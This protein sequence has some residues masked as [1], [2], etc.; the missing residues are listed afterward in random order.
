FDDTWEFPRN[1]LTLENILGEGEFGQVVRAQAKNLNGHGSTTVVAVKMLKP[2]ASGTEYQDLASEFQLM[3]E[4]DHPNVVKLLGVCS[5]KGPL[6]LIVEYCEFGS[7]RSFLRASQFRNKGS[8]DDKKRRLDNEEPEGDEV[9]EITIRDLFVFAWQI[10]KG[11][12]YLAGLKIV[13]RDLAA[14]NVLVTEGLK[15]KISDFGLSRD[16]YEMDTY[17]KMS[18]G[19]I[20]VKWMA[21]ESLY[22][23][24]YTTKSDIWSY[25]IVLWET[26]TLGASPY[27]G[28][29]AERLFPLL[30]TGYRMDRPE[31]CPDELYAIMQKC[32][33]SEPEQ[34]PTFAELVRFL[35]NILQQN[36]D[37]LDLSNENYIGQ[38]STFDIEGKDLLLSMD[39]EIKQQSTPSSTNTDNNNQQKI[40]ST[41]NKLNMYRNLKPLNSDPTD[42]DLDLPVTSTI[43][44]IAK[45]DQEPDSCFQEKNEDDCV[46]ESEPETESSRLLSQDLNTEIKDKDP[47]LILPPGGLGSAFKLPVSKQEQNQSRYRADPTRE[48]RPRIHENLTYV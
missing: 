46:N 36:T 14:R 26:V 48:S 12:D 33:K 38:S 2:E 23:Q 11:M 24:V 13:H 28:I 4:V 27:P 44:E 9:R 16:V 6:Y 7:L 32:W 10:A 43:E 31:E 39:T 21:P 42:P 41:D 45:V 37:Y 1:D 15:L 29:P 20:P 47:E 35:E 18:K 30:T 8:W 19:R 40:C 34:R 3:K 17:L 5:H 22:G 25:G